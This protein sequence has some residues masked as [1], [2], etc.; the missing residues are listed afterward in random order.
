MDLV[1]GV[2]TSPVCSA[3]RTYCSMGNAAADFAYSALNRGVR[4]RHCGAKRE[5]YGQSTLEI[6]LHLSSSDLR[7][8]NP[9]QSS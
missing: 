5:I 9:G 1:K 6:S 3:A 8:P 2:S 4:T 7:L